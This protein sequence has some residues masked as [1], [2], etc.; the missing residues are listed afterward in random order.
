LALID[1]NPKA[2]HGQKHLLLSKQKTI[3]AHVIPATRQAGVA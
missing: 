2:A 1:S 3:D